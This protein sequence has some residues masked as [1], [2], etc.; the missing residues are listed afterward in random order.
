MEDNPIT[1]IPYSDDLIRTLEDLSKQVE[2]SMRAGASISN[3]EWRELTDVTAQLIEE[4]TANNRLTSHPYQKIRRRSWTIDPAV[5]D[6]LRRQTVLVTGAAGEI[7]RL[8]TLRLAGYCPRRLILVDQSAELGN[9]SATVRKEFANTE[10]VDCRADIASEPD[11]EALFEQY[12]PHVVF[13]LAAQRE[14]Q[15][16]ESLVRETILTNIRGTE[17]LARMADAHRVS[18]FIHASTGKCRFLFEKRVYPASKK[19]AEVMVKLVADESETSFSVV[20]FHHVVDNSIVERTFQSQADRDAAVTPHLPPDR[21]Q[22]GQ[23]AQEAVAML[24]NAGVKG[25]NAEVFGSTHQTDYFSV[26]DLALFTIKQSGKRLPVIFTTPRK[27]E[28]YHYREF[29]GTRLQ[30]SPVTHSFNLLETSV[31]KITASLNL[32]MAPF[33]DFEPGPIRSGIRQLLDSAAHGRPTA[34]E[35][36]GH[37]FR[38]LFEFAQDVCSRASTALLSKSLVQGV[39]PKEMPSVQ[40]YEPH[41]E[42]IALLI[43]GLLDRNQEEFD[44]AETAGLSETLEHLCA[45]LEN[46]TPHPNLKAKARELA[47]RITPID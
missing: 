30:G 31:P 28:G 44:P 4:G 22:H 1:L 35:L 23:S 34:D 6:S 36:K 26:L 2:P 27:D 39:N 41:Q 5:D 13:H 42:T 24:L 9:F 20:R 37:L 33:P 40:D 32:I 3:R 47:T 12:Q 25:R 11:Q 45:L 8:L 38:V 10:L 17:V 19:L 46:L 15:K 14:P 18:R 16:S 21:M 7:G 43:G 29:Y